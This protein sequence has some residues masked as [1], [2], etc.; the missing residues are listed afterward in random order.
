LVEQLSQREIECNLLQ[1]L[2]NALQC[3]F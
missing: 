3:V 2:N 1:R